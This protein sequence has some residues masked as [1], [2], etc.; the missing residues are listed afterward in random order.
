MLATETR[1]QSAL[2][3][4]ER[5]RVDVE[6]GACL[7]AREPERDAMREVAAA[8]CAERWSSQE[9]QAMAADLRQRTQQQARVVSLHACA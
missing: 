7:F 5:S 3:E 1:L 6:K 4:A 8:A 9:V 2:M